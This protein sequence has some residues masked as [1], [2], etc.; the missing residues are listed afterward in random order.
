[1]LNILNNFFQTHYDTATFSTIIFFEISIKYVIFY[2]FF[3]LF[4]LLNLG[5]TYVYTG[6]DN[7][8]ELIELPINLYLRF[9][10]Y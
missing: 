10:N 7:Y 2:I 8:F 4:C 5:L 9:F 1:M 3:L 6:F